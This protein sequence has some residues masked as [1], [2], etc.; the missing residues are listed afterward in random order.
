MEIKIVHFEA[1]DNINLTGILYKNKNETNKILISVHG[2]VSN[3]LKKRDEEIAKKL[4]NINI[5]VLAFNNRG[6]DIVNYIKKKNGDNIISGTAFEDVEDGYLDILGAIKFALNKG[7]KE[8]YLMGHSLGST[9]VVYS[10][11]KFLEKN[12]DIVKNIKA[13]ILLSLVDIPA[14]LRIYLNDKFPET[15][16]YAK[17]MEQAGMEN[18]LMPEKSFIHPVSIKTFLKYARDYQNIDFAKYSEKEYDFKELNN[19]EVPLFMRWGN[20][21]ELILQDAQKLCEFLK[22]K[23]KN[24]N[25]DINYIDGANHSYKGKEEELGEE[26]KNFLG[27]LN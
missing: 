15:L 22:G 11:N 3:C 5:D 27:K 9:K 8:I 14:T 18:I 21:N 23:I 16:K 7:Y 17:D 26:I 24:N 12:K 19:I 25:L 10:Y 20:I 1:D 6:H 13:I 4:E 2:M